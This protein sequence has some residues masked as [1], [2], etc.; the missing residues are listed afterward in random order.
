M[1]EAAGRVNTD[2][3]YI[4]VM[5]ERDLPKFDRIYRHRDEALDVWAEKI[6]DL[7]ANEVY[8]Y[9]DNYFEGFAPATVN[10]LLNR[11]GLPPGDPA[12]LEEQGSLF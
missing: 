11:L 4:R 2:F 6:R 3:R 10:K 1:F 12:T 9:S 5:G 7:S 8:I